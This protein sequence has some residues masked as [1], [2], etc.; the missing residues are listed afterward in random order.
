MNS[1][2]DSNLKFY[3]PKHHA[4]LWSKRCMGCSMC[5][6]HHSIAGIT[7]NADV[8]DKAKQWWNWEFVIDEIDDHYICPLVTSDG[9]L[10]Q[11]DK[12]VLCK[13]YFCMGKMK[14]D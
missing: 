10:I 14:Y 13:I 4:E 2:I 7:H 3:N 6:Y 8:I 11:D 5:C 9:C 1:T 12:P